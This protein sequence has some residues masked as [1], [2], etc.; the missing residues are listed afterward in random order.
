MELLKLIKEFPKGEKSYYNVD[1]D[2]D[3]KKNEITIIIVQGILG[4]KKKKKI[5]HTIKSEEIKLSWKKGINTIEKYAREMANKIYMKKKKEGYDYFIEKGIDYNENLPDE[6]N[7]IINDNNQKSN[8][9]NNDNSSIKGETNNKINE[10]N[11][12]SNNTNNNKTKSNSDNNNYANLNHEITYISPNKLIIPTFPVEH[13][14]FEPMLANAYDKRTK[15]DLVFPCYVQPKLDGVRCVVVD[16]ELYSRYGNKFPTLSHIKEELKLNT[17]NLLLDGELYTDDINFEKI[18]GLVKKGKKTQEEE[19][20]SLKIYFNVFDYIEPSLTCEQRL[21]NLH[22]FFSKHQFKYL[23]L[24]KTELCFSEEEIDYY[25]DKFTKEGYEGVMMRNIQGKYQPRIRSPHLFKLKKFL[26]ADFPIVGFS[27]P[28][29]GSEHG[30][31]IWICRARNGR[32]FHVKPLNSLE[33]RRIQFIHGKEYIG[34]KLTVKYQV[35]TEYGVP[36]FPVGLRIRD[37]E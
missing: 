8:S 11:L 31:V 3:I 18:V 13:R 37:Y 10:N 24:V 12:N 7:N 29:R 35:F 34:K 1:A 20:R 32:T 6:N 22:Y 28:D 27:A 16:T 26:E 25:L 23:R 14:F 17:D 21:S 30:C 36:R 4:K 5:T 15:A 9:I 2:I 19:N 33:D